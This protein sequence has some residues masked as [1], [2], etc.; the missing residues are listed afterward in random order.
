MF[1][2]AI[3]I[4]IY[5]YLIFLLG[6]LGFIYR[7]HIILL[8][9]IYLAIALYSYREKLK[10]NLLRCFETFKKIQ[11]PYLEKIFL[12]IIILQAL[13]N[14]VGVLGPELAFDALWY[15]LT[16]PKIYITNHSISH[17]PGGLLYYSDMPK[18]TEMIYVS[19]LTF[20][21]EITAK[22]IHFSFGILIL[23]AIYLSLIH[24]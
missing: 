11:K 7:Q 6:V 12:G 10:M 17:I 9:V 15:H 21:N 5:S 14:L 2:T 16:L 13:I 23:I 19:A 4:G 1:T 3:L 8:T 20:G 24:I 18:L 22:F